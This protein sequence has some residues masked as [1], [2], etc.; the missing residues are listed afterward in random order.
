MDNDTIVV[1]LPRDIIELQG[2]IQCAGFRHPDMHQ[3][4]HWHPKHLNPLEV[5]PG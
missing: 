5:E 4:R 1:N 3:N 2:E